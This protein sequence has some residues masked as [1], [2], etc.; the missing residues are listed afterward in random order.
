MRAK[1]LTQALLGTILMAAPAQAQ[2]QAQTRPT[3]AQPAGRSARRGPDH[4]V[5][6]MNM[7]KD[8]LQ[9]APAFQANR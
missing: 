4:G 8:Q 2:G 6:T 9:A 3:A 7:T 1:H 5:L